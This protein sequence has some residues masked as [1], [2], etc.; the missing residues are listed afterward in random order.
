VQWTVLF[1]V[2]GEA[3]VRWTMG[4]MQRCVCILF[5]HGHWQG[6]WREGVDPIIII[7]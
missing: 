6:H 7:E 5:E 3:A 2:G 1:V 4:G